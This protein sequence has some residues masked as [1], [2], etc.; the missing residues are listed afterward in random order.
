M[1]IFKRLE[2]R[3]CENSEEKRRNGIEKAQLEII[4]HVARDVAKRNCKLGVRIDTTLIDKM[5]KRSNW[6][7]IDKK[8]VLQKWETDNKELGDSKILD[9]I[10]PVNVRGHRYVIYFMLKG[11]QNRG[12]SQDNS[13]GEMYMTTELIRKNKTEHAHFIFMLDGDFAKSK[14]GE[15]KKNKKYS[16][17][18]SSELDEV[19][20]D[21]ITNFIRDVEEMK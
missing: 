6:F 13:L 20:H 5:K 3:L 19:L 16:V 9:V 2:E 14:K 4:K 17:I 12:G 1:D 8:G 10:L 18:D 11:I 7:F 15:F 21:T